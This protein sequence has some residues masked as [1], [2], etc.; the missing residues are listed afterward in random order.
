MSAN[1]FH[2]SHPA[3]PS[4][5]LSH[6]LTPSHPAH[7]SH[8]ALAGVRQLALSPSWKNVTVPVTPGR[9]GRPRT[10]AAF[11][12]FLDSKCLLQHGYPLP[13]GTSFYPVAVAQLPRSLNATWLPEALH[14]AEQAVHYMEQMAIYED[15]DGDGVVDRL[16]YNASAGMAI[17]VL[18][19]GP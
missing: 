16:F 1:F 13:L 9:N 18:H 17:Q 8:P 12:S 14:R 7:P 10:D 3:H 2:P 15:G 19:H 6:P 5:T 4:H 11:G